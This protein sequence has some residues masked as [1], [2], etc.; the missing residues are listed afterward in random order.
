ME[1]GNIRMVHLYKLHIF[2]LMGRL[3]I[4]PVCVLSTIAPVDHHLFVE[5]RHRNSL[6]HTMENIFRILSD[7]FSNIFLSHQ[8]QAIFIE[9]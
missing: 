8:L 2:C 7:L 4:L 5:T 3:A 6:V 1:Y 9:H